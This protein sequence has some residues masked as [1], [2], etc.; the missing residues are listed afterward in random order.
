MCDKIET[1]RIVLCTMME[2]VTQRM[3]TTYL[4][5][6]LQI[7]Y[8]SFKN[9]CINLCTLLSETHRPCILSIMNLSRNVL[10]EVKSG[11][12]AGHFI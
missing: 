3:L 8:I 11:E 5:F 10:A 9:I 2:T 12:H 6:E 4:F 1:F 7:R